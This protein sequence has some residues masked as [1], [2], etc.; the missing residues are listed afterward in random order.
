VP[1][2]RNAQ[3]AATRAGVRSSD[4]SDSGDAF[5]Y[6]VAMVRRLHFDRGKSA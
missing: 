5:A 3:D 6:G 4:R 1:I 2:L